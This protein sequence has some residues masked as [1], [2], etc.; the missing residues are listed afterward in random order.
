MGGGA[1]TCVARASLC[2]NVHPILASLS[3]CSLPLM[4]V[5]A[6]TLWSVVVCVRACNILAIDS[7]IFKSGWLLCKVGC[8]VCV[9]MRYK[10]LRQ[11]VKICAGSL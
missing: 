2:T 7:S 1:C 11:S 3:A 6:L 4:F 9:F 10:T 8:F 5:W